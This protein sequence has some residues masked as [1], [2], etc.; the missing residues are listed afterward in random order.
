MISRTNHAKRFWKTSF[1]FLIALML[2]VPL[3]QAHAATY[4]S[5]Y[6]FVARDGGRP[7]GIVLDKT[8]TLFGVTPGIVYE[9]DPTT[10]EITTLYAFSGGDDGASANGAP[11]IDSSGALYG[12]TSKGGTTKNCNFNCGVVFKLTPPSAGKTAWTETVLHDFSGP[13]GG[14]PASLVFGP[15]GIL[16][17]T[18]L[19]GNDQ[20]DSEGA[21]GGIF[22]LTPPAAGIR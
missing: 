13:D 11:V 1:F 4:Q 19:T 5:L 3:S 6:S 8:G 17:G 21:W 22:K 18:V 10:K 20:T 12:T 16:Y 9:F 2:T 7:Q 14:M 15:S